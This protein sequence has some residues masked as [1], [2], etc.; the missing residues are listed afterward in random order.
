MTCQMYMFLLKQFFVKSTNYVHDDYFPFKRQ[1]AR[2]KI[3]EQSWLKQLKV[4]ISTR[5]KR[6]TR[7][8]STKFVKQI[9]STQVRFLVNAELAKNS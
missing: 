2:A 1:G 3:L 7:V 5:G 8:K 6:A 9:L 4:V